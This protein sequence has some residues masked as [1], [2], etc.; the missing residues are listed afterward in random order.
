ML[1]IKYLLF[2][3]LIGNEIH[4]SVKFLYFSFVFYVLERWRVGGLIVR[5]L[6]PLPPHTSRNYM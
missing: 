2:E 3:S 6:T 1:L 4:V 5:K